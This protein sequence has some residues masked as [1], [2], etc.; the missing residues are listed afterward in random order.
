MTYLWSL[1]AF[2]GL[3]ESPTPDIQLHKPIAFVASIEC[4][5]GDA[6]IVCELST[7]IEPKIQCWFLPGGFEACQEKQ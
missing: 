7:G 6:P 4:P 5:L 3:V 2:L 1:F